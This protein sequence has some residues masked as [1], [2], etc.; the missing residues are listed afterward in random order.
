MGADCYTS[1]DSGQDFEERNMLIM[2]SLLPTMVCLA[3]TAFAGPLPAET[4][5]KTGKFFGA[6]ETQYPAWFK[7]SFLDLK[8]DVEEAKHAGKRLMLFFHQDGCPYCNALVERNLAQKDIEKKMRKNFDVVALNMWGD[9]EITYFDGTQYTEKTFAEA[10][11]VQFTPTLVFYDESGNVVLRLNGYRSPKRFTVD[12]DYVAQH[13]EKQIAY[14][15]YIKA[16][17]VAGPAHHQLNTEDFFRAPPFDLTRKSGSRPLAVFFEQKDCPN[18]DILHQQVLVDPATRK[19]IQQFDAVQLNMWSDTPVITPGGEKTT[20][21]QWAKQLDIKYA[22]SIV[23][24]NDKG[25]EVIRSEAYFKVFHT[26][27][28][29]AYVLEGA[30]KTQPSFQRYLTERANRIREKG[31]DVDIWRTAGEKP[32]SKK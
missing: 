17:F 15:D 31:Q 30:Y 26:Q 27:G 18:C 20:A 19:V 3:A 28:I 32:A 7:D 5:E 22:P 13:K 14:R 10:M 21:R 23:L 6:K 24:F 25:E 11:K 29:F 12:L 2:R 8:E 16:N 9:R 1:L 4:E